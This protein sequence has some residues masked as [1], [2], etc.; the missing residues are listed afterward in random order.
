MNY[1]LAINTLGVEHPPFG[2]T[3]LPIALEA[4]EKALTEGLYKSGTKDGK[5]AIQLGTGTI[6]KLMSEKA[7]QE[8][9]DDRRAAKASPLIIP[10]K[11][12]QSPWKLVVQLGRLQLPPLDYDTEDEADEAVEI[13][14]RR[15]VSSTSSRKSTT[16]SGCRSARAPFT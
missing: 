11:D 6:I 2:Y 1:I 16:I 7:V 4:V 8:L 13:A 15:G 14:V 9:Q 5:V 10:G 3:E 12:R